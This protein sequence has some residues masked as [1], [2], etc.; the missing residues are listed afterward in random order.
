M[1]WASLRHITWSLAPDL[2]GDHQL[3]FSRGSGRSRLEVSL[4]HLVRVNALAT[5]SPTRFDNQFAETRIMLSFLRTPASGQLSLREESVRGSSHHIRQFVVECL[6]L[7]LHS[8]AVGEPRVLPIG[9][10]RA[11]RNRGVRPDLL[12]GWPGRRLA[13]EAKGRAR[14]APSRVLAEPRLRLETMLEWS[15]RH[16]DHPFVMTWAYASDLGITVDLYRPADGSAWFDG[17]S[18]KVRTELYQGPAVDDSAV[19]PLAE[20]AATRVVEVERYL[21]ETAPPTEHTLLGHRLR[22]AQAPLDLFGLDSRRYALAVLGEDLDEDEHAALKSSPA[23]SVSGR[24]VVVLATDGGDPWTA[25][26]EEG[27]A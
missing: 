6:G 2:L 14:N 23:V 15:A 27:L 7:G 26:K 17:N 5:L 16:D 10:D 1:T 11:Y 24:I 13:G 9:P 22:G 19:G 3:A 21:H 12:F 25:I 8:T 20:E 18:G 4:A